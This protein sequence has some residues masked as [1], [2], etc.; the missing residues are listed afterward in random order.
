MKI[1]LIGEL[2]MTHEQLIKEYLKRINEAKDKKYVTSQ[3]INEINGLTY[4]NTRLPISN[5]DKKKILNGLRIIIITES[6]GF[7][8]QDNKEHLDLIEQAKNY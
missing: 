4:T 7:F 2:Y 1:T 8:A 3:I 6:Q 5:E